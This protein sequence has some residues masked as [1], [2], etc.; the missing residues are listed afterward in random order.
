M[1]VWK[2]ARYLE[3]PAGGFLNPHAMDVFELKTQDELFPFE[4]ET[5]TGGEMG[6]TVDYL[7]RYILTGN[8]QESFSISLKGAS[9][10]KELKTAEQL[11]SKIKGLDEE[12][13]I[14]AI[15]LTS[16]DVVVRNPMA[17]I[18][19]GWS[20]AMTFSA[21][22]ITN[23]QIMVNRCLQFFEEYGP[24]ID[25]ELVFPG[26]YTKNVSSGD[27]DYM[28]TD[29]I[30]DIKTTQKD[31]SISDTFQLLLY[32]LMSQHSELDKYSTIKKIGIYNPRLNK[33]HIISINDIDKRI[34]HYINRFIIGYKD[35]E[36]TF[37]GLKEA[38][39]SRPKYPHYHSK[40]GIAKLLDQLIKLDSPDREI[41]YLIR[42]INSELIRYKL[43]ECI[44][45]DDIKTAK[46]AWEKSVEL[47]KKYNEKPSRPLLDC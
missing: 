1:M 33:I 36:A 4:M 13:I 35:D 3:Q 15:R 6:M 44:E 30:W 10:V 46:E 11:I 16:F 29:T 21:E 32:Y 31:V 18:K 22:T 8:L 37:K 17:F 25:Q 24:V 45:E 43:A 39:D 34:L 14:A 19:G 9:K 20:P 38:L 7:T 42:T 28:T 2:V 23:I 26:A 5:I 47:M 12:S 41:V 27:A 40:R